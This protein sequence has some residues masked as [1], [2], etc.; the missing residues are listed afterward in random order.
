[1][2]NKGLNQ[3]DIKIRNRKKVL[4][5]LREQSGISR[6]DISDQ[7]GLSKAAI[8]SIIS[9]MIE[10]KIIMESGSQELASQESGVG[11]HKIQL[12]INRSCGYAIGLSISNNSIT[13]L[14]SN[15][16]GE[17]IDSY[18]YEFQQNEDCENNKIVDLI[19]DKSLALLWN[20]DIDRSLVVGVGISY[21]GEFD[22]ININDI[23]NRLTEKLKLDVFTENNVKALAMYQMDFGLDNNRDD[24]LFVKYGPGLGMAIVQNGAIINGA[25]HRA[26]EIGH[27]VVDITA[28]TTCRCGR[29][30]CLES[31]ISEVG[32]VNEIEKHWPAY[33]YLIKN[34]HLAI[35]DYGIVDALLEENNEDIKSIFERRY[36]YLA[37]SLANAIILFNP[38]YIY[39]YGSIFNRSTIFTLIK[40]RM[41]DYLGTKNKTVIKLSDLDPNNAA[42]GSIALVLRE[43]FY[44]KGGVKSIQ[45]YA[46]VDSL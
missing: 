43:N 31:L 32:I 42:I 4:N 22:S 2:T 18:F 16:L 24:F 14:I 26:G 29:K 37:K 15:I 21:I 7:M 11:R 17:S 45:I 46:N 23:K 44:N 36:D 1:M 3:N 9:E 6:K 28:D 38:K 20:N 40:N 19:V 33:D 30:G 34:K 39:L 25:D 41:T 5:I 8:T 27:T 12:E 13:L 10:E 35:I